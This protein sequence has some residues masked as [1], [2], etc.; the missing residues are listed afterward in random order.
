MAPHSADFYRKAPPDRGASSFIHPPTPANIAFFAE[1]LKAGCLVAIPTE[2]V[3]GLAG[4]ALRESAC[5]SIFEV[6]G[7]PLVDPL[8]VHVASPDWVARL[9]EIPDEFKRLTEAFWPGPLTLIL[10]KKPVVP[11]LVTA[12]HETVAVRMPRQPVA[13][14]L[15]EKLGQPVAA[16]SANPFGYVS[17]TRPEHVAE[18]FGPQVPFILDGG[19][20]EI[21]IES[22]ILD[23]SRPGTPSILRPGAITEENLK[24]KLHLHPN[25]DLNPNRNHAPPAPGTLPRHYSPATQ[26]LLFPFKSSPVAAPREA[27]VYLQRPSPPVSRDTYWLSEDG[28]PVTIAQSLFALLRQLDHAGHPRIHCECPPPHSTGLLLAVRDRLNRAAAQ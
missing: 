5:R 16:P 8:I 20:C 22:T 25:L 26:L 10:R 1:A 19:P 11:D 21:G 24:L 4:L 6:K 13:H 15:L 23:L 7:R 18:S 27:V 14:A 2:T 9:A 3:Y 12:G 28:N 17:P